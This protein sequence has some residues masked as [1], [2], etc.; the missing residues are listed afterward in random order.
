MSRMTMGAAAAGAGLIALAAGSAR[1]D[2]F[3]DLA[4]FEGATENL[5]LLNFDVDENGRAF[6]L[7]D[8]IGDRYG[9]LGIHFPAGNYTAGGNGAPSL[10][11]G[12][13]NDTTPDGGISRVFDAEFTASDVTAVGVYQ[14]LAAGGG[15]TSLVAFDAQ[16]GVLGSVSGDNDVDTVDFFGL[17]TTSP[18]SRIEVTFT[19]PGGWGLDNLYFGQQVP[20]PS[21]GVALCGG[22]LL[23]GR[24][25][26]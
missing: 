15:G 26:R 23:A 8:Q 1:G 6:N 3:N 19:N 11:N 21:A 9:T 14:L 12:W 25:R 5:V 17:T 13:F 10:P 2:T 18:I 24:R 7:F 4:S 22:L 16:G 20:A